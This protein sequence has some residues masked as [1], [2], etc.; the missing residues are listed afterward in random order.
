MRHKGYYMKPANGPTVPS[1]VFA[2]AV[3][4]QEC[5]SAANELIS[6]RQFS[7]A[8]IY[9]V[10]RYKGIWTRTTELAADSADFAQAFI[11][12]GAM[13][14]RR[15]WVVTPNVV[16]TLTL[17]NWFGWA[18]SIGIEWARRKKGKGERGYEPTNPERVTIRRINLF[19]RSQ[20]IDYAYRNCR[21]VWVSGTN[22]L[23][24][25]EEELSSELCTKWLETEHIDSADMTYQRTARERAYLWLVAFMRLSDWWAGA[26]KAPFGLTAG[27]CAIGILRSNIVRGDLCTHTDES[28]HRLEREASFGGRAST[29]YYGD[30]GSPGRY[31]TD[32]CPAPADSHYPYIPGPAHLVDV[33][34][35]YPSLLYTKRFP[36][37]L[38]CVRTKPDRTEPQSMT[39]LYGVIA[40][41]RIR[42][43]VAEYPVRDG[44]RVVYPVGTFNTV[45][46]GIELDRLHKDGEVLQCHEMAL[47]HMG[48]PFKDA[49]RDMLEM[50]IQ[51]RKGGNKSWEMYA[52]LMANS[53]GGKLAQ[54]SGRWK[55][56]RNKVPV[57]RWGE[58]VEPS[59]KGNGVTRWRAIAGLA[60]EWISDDSAPGPFTAAFAYLTAYGRV[61]MR[62]LREC[63][64][65]NSVYSQDTDGIWVDTRALESI[66]DAG[67]HIGD[68]PGSLAIQK[69]VPAA[70][71]YGPRHYWI[72]GEWLLA[73]MSAPRVVGS[74]TNAWDVYTLSPVGRTS[75]SAPT[76]V[77]KV[78]RKSTLSVKRAPGTV[79]GFGWLHPPTFGSLEN[80]I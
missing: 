41:V 13:P 27:Q 5:G 80:P 72:P 21:Y 23:Q 53:L 1:S 35:M 70:R 22:Y 11:R 39:R 15:N 77:R 6:D 20:L 54:R 68:T 17:I 74:G 14:N 26:S 24:M 12:S 50:R 61:S 51:A 73:G 58:W 32:K 28:A 10:R 37:A 62:E 60:W 8:H 42:T 25:P 69:T 4:T 31:H 3:A 67:Y 30:I 45:L 29:W 38:K 36:R 59:G 52:K 64:P 40:A 44:D 47:Y 34:S 63:C 2:I 18:D 55:E 79:D 57:V 33:R 16:E 56:R 48:E 46:T 65:D 66:R 75:D 78:S 7:N 76:T 43:R 19:S 49:A 9:R 71:W